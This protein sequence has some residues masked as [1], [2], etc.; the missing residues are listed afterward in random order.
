MR[1]ILVVTV[2]LVAF[3]GCGGG[4]ARREARAPS[5][6]QA[7]EKTAT[8]QAAL[9]TT[10]TTTTTSAMVGGPS[11]DSASVHANASTNA[12]MVQ[13]ATPPVSTSSSVMRITTA[14]CDREAACNHVGTGKSFADKDECFNAV[15]HDVVTMLGAGADECPSGID[16]DRLSACVKEL[17]AQACDGGSVSASGVEAAP[18]C[19]R[20]RLCTRSF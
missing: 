20:D 7:H 2:A 19:G 16:A 14:R 6:A 1:R 10:S 12:A 3:A 4:G 8:S 9:T 17:E 5:K 15:G 11:V 18:S 13:A